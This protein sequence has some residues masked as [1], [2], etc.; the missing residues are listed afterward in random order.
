MQIIYV[1]LLLYY[2]FERKDTPAWAKRIVTGSIA[3]LLLP[4]DGLP[5][6][7]PFIGFTDDLGV[8]SFGLVAIAAHINEE[9]RTKAVNKLA[10]LFPVVDQTI[11]D[12][13]DAKL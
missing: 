4:F 13:I 6:F 10:Q 11:I 8:L 1:T 12:D 9:V 3:Y 2:A 7:T 5:D